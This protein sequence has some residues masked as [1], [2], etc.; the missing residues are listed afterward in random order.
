MSGMFYHCLN[1]TK[2]DLSNFDT[3]NVTTMGGNFE[4]WL[5]QYGDFQRTYYGDKAGMFEGCSSLTA[6]IIPFDT[7]HVEDFCGMFC[8]CKKLTVLDISSFD[9]SSAINMNCM[10]DYCINL[11]I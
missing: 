1:L 3:S 4:Y 8:G 7:S 11:M 10:F 6:L 9:T 5:T 2:L